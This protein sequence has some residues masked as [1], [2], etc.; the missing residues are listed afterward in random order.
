[1]SRTTKP[2]KPTD[3]PRRRLVAVG[4]V[5]AGLSVAGAGAA[6]AVAPHTS[7]ADAVTG[8]L[9]AFGVQWSP[10]G[11]TTFTPEELDA[12]WAA[13]YT[14]GDLEALVDLWDV[15]AV[16][17][18]ATA[19]RMILGGETVPVLPGSHPDPAPVVGPD[20]AQSDAFFGAG[21]TYDDAVALAELWDADPIETKAT[22]GQMLLDGETLPV[23]PSGTADTAS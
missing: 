6:A 3:R 4:V 15:D 10:G 14:G 11:E 8:A 13:G 17:A 12:F 22:A 1:M 20:Q 2:T 19:G 9:G 5:A 7:V 16:E 18:K 23:P 21:Y